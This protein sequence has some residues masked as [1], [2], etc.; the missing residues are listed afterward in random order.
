MKRFYAFLLFTLCLLSVSQVM[1]QEMTHRPRLRFGINFGG[2]WQ[3]SDIRDIGGGGLGATLE[4]PIVENDHSWLGIGLR[5]RYLWTVTYGKDLE[6]TPDAFFPGGINYLNHRTSATNWDLELLLKANRLRAKTGILLYVWGGVGVMGSKAKQNNYEEFF[7]STPYN[8]T[9]IGTSSVFSRATELRFLR[10]DTY[11]T[12]THSAWPLWKFAPS[13]GIGFGYEFTPWFAMSAEWKVTFPQ[14]DMLDGYVAAN[15]NLLDYNKDIHNYV[16]L[17]LDFGMFGSHAHTNPQPTDPNVYTPKGDAPAI[18]MVNP[19]GPHIDLNTGCTY[20]VSARLYNVRNKGLISFSMNGVEVNPALWNYDP[21]GGIFTATVNLGPGTNSF[22]I[23]ARNQY[24]TDTKS[25]TASCT[26]PVIIPN[27]PIPVPGGNPPQVF[28]TYPTACPA[29]IA[30]CRSAINVTFYNVLRQDE[31]SVIHNG[32]QV[33]PQYYNFNPQSGQLVM[34]IDL[35]PGDHRIEFIARTPY[36]YASA[37]AMLRCPEQQAQLPA[38]TITTPGITPYA[39]PN[40]TQTVVAA[41]TG[42]QSK[43][44]IQVYVDRNMLSPNAWSYNPSSRVVTLTVSM[45]PGVQSMVEIMA[46]NQFGRASDFQMISCYQ[47]LPPPVV[48]IVYPNNGVYQGTDCNQGISARIFNISGIQDIRVL[49]G[50]TTI[51]PQ[52]YSFNPM[53][54]LFTMDVNLTPTIREQFTII[55]T[56]TVGQDQATVS[57]Q[58]NQPVEQV[59]TICHIPPSNPANVQTITIP[60]SQWAGH[61]AHGDVQ[62]A[63]SNA[64]VSVCYQGSTIAVSQSALP[65]LLNL[66]ATQGPCQ[67]PKIQICHIPPGNPAAASTLTVPQSAW[68]A[69]QAHGDIQ[70]ACSSTM[71]TI[72]Y[73]GQNISVSQTVWPV[74]QGLGATNGPCPPQTITICHIPPTNPAAVQT[75]TIPQSQWAS[76]QAHGDIQGPC[77][78]V[79]I[80]ICYQNQT[81][82]ISQSAWPAFQSLGA[83]RGPCPV[84]NITICH[85]PPGNPAAAATMTIPETDWATHQGHG[86]IQGACATQQVTLCYQGQTIQVSATAVNAML[87]IG[88][89][90]GPC[91][92]RQIQ[93]CHLPPDNPANA[94]TITIPETAWAS[95]QAHGDIQGPCSTNMITICYQ[96]QT[97]VI[98]ESAWAYYQGRGAT[99][100]PCPVRTI[101]ICHIPPGNPNN[102][103]TISIPES[104]WPAHEAHG[105]TRGACNLTPMTICHKEGA[106][107][108]GVTMQIPT[109]AWPAHQAHGDTQGACPVASITICHIPPANPNSPQTMTIP[110]SEWP[111]HQ[112]HGDTQGACD[113]TTVTICHHG[114]SRSE[115]NQTIQVP[116]ASVPHHLSHGDTEGE[117]PVQDITICHIPPGNPGNPQTI[118]IAPS[119]WPAHQAHGDTQGA[120]NMT[121]MT[122]CADGTT[123]QIP[124]SS[125]PFYQSGGAT[126]GPCPIQNITICHI[127]PSDPGNPQTMTIPMSQWPAHQ[128]HG[129]VREAC[130]MAPMS[131]CYEGRNIN[132]PTASWPWYQS[133][134]AIQGNCP[135][136]DITI[137]HIPPGNPSNPQT[138]TVAPSAWPAHQS[139][140]DTQGACN[141]TMIRI[142]FNGTTMQIPT[143][144]WA[145]YQGQGAEEGECEEQITICHIPPGNPNNPQ[146]ITVPASAWPAHQGH[147]D[148]QGAC[149]MTLMAICLEGQNLNVP[150]SS[151]P[152]YQQQGATQGACPEQQITICHFPPGNPGNPQTITVAASAWPAHQG[153]GDTQ[154]ACN[155]ATMAICVDGQN[156]NIPTASWP[157]Y[158]SQGATQGACPEQQITICHIPPGNPGNPQTI[159]VAASAWPAHQGHGDTQG[160]CNMNMTTICLNGTTMTVPI[161]SWAVYEGQGAIEGACPEVQVTICHIPPGN[162]SNAQ[163]MTIPLSAWPAH[164]AHG[165][166]QSA[167]NMRL[168]T[169]CAD[170]TTLQ[171][172]T[173]SWPVYQQQGATQ[174]ACPEAQITICHIP[175]GNPENP[176]TITVPQSAWPA[177]QGHGDT[178]GACNMTM[179]TICADGTTMQIP[180][181]SWPFYQNGGATQG[182]CPSQQITICHFPPG[183]PNNPQTLTIAAN[184]WPAHQS[185]HGDTQGACNMMP[186]TICADGTTMQ[187]PT[188]SWP[189]YQNGGATQGPCAQRPNNAPVVPKGGGQPGKPSGEVVKTG[190]KISICHTPP[191]N[192]KGPK[193]TMEIQESEWAAHAKHGDTRGPCTAPG[194]QIQQA[195]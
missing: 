79:M 98:S 59:I 118:T 128:G 158:Q 27:D 39:S 46:V 122:I 167:C 41:V 192:P 24:G 143:A 97:I 179:M 44:D 106:S 127:P 105:D 140:G 162:P 86:D 112:A 94:T 151:W 49:S 131:I 113:M 180:T 102:A 163:T 37:I 22:Q 148:T 169:I 35:T 77:S 142:C 135:V 178:Q 8:Y 42:V 15:D 3:C 82:S 133:H 92:P 34:N 166:Q 156:M 100:G 29:I 32:L 60:V 56:N 132:I 43:N 72:C 50:N 52:Y 116:R 185:Q 47:Q 16:G 91:P 38:V 171:V 114:A 62:G 168:M 7:S 21:T 26:Q 129:D 51:S 78:N 184:A 170:G 190:A 154:G 23:V 130:N 121:P 4:V 83:T 84:R 125:W 164:Q 157:L 146:T 73:Q 14:T 138:I 20:E 176:Q 90:E 141:M 88:A 195:K 103:Q 144:S 11:E 36:G 58:C 160:A 111:A 67:E 74:Y 159:T 145:Y 177:H 161:A 189:F 147:G 89:T 101:E 186:M 96:N 150:T 6:S 85:I 71:V 95:H 104:A 172:P 40:C 70:G 123:I 18:V 9:S 153:H 175:P 2:A 108:T 115:G 19:S 80:E 191:E 54:Q 117:C 152:V 63:C 28:V 110:Q 65:A 155:M 137:C 188:A 174:G 81:M 183:S 124:T 120:C 45:L 13:A 57:L 109:A 76:H 194:K 139:H 182:P 12:R 64:T 1:A 66:G 119:A 126:Q 149:N 30:N 193:V 181:S 33:P 134:G 69:H 31:I 53:N 93:I 61:Q 99:R 75:M 10:D 136:Q 173:S 17:N 165:D 68:P 187:I 55:A 48:Q 107:R 87:N 5:A 25:F